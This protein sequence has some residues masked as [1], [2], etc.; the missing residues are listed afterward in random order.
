MILGLFSIL[1]HGVAA[2]FSG[3]T[4]IDIIFA[5]NQL[6]GLSLMLCMIQLLEF[7]SIHHLFGPWGVI[8]GHLVID[9]LRFLV[10]MLIFVIGFAM[11]LGAVFKPLYLEETDFQIKSVDF[12]MAMIVELLF[13]GLFGLTAQT[14]FNVKTEKY[15]ATSF[16][17][18]KAVFGLYNVLCLIV[19]VNLLIAM[20]SDTYQRIQERS[21]V[22][23]K[24]GRAK[25]IRNMERDAARPV[26]LNLFILVFNFL[27]VLVKAR[28]NCC[29]ADFKALMRVEE[30]KDRNGPQRSNGRKRKRSRVGDEA[31]ENGTEE[32]GRIQSVVDWN[33]MIMK[34]YDI[35]GD[36]ANHVPAKKSGDTLRKRSPP[37][38][39]PALEFGMNSAG[40]NTMKIVNVISAM[41]A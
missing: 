13:F 30:D 33:E 20:M 7:L 31:I 16:P 41:K 36:L 34:Y 5:R 4:R 40:Q 38:S 29:S 9:V 21:D 28:C 32:E 11:Q 19:L 39:G 14:M 37:K 1:L 17:I 23:W 18:A 35:K 3:G 2:A 22:E 24:F 27:K 26:P 10:I 6:L 8:I 25:L 12:G 15:P